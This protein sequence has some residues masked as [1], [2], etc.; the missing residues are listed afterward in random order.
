MPASP[1]TWAGLAG[2]LLAGRLS[3]GSPSHPLGYREFAGPES[4]PLAWIPG[5]GSVALFRSASGFRVFCPPRVFFSSAGR[6]SPG[7]WPGL[8]AFHWEFS[9][10]Q[11]RWAWKSENSQ[12]TS[13]EN[14][15]PEK[16][17]KPPRGIRLSRV[18]SRS[19]YLCLPLEWRAENPIFPSPLGLEKVD[20]PAPV[21]GTRATRP[22]RAATAW[23]PSD[24][25]GPLGYVDLEAY[26]ILENN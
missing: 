13:Q 15:G 24:C 3:G 5:S 9:I 26:Y 20:S 12:F 14:T 2:K 10:F 6:N 21:S 7:P 25:V 16:T 22:A 11:A 17:L 23:A 8:S 18:P 4:N 19:V 1:R